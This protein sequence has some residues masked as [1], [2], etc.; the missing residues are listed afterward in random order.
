MR[1]C[2]QGRFRQQIKFLR[3][4][5]LQDGG[6][7]FSDVL[8]EESVAQ[9]LTAIG[10]SSDLSTPD[11]AKKSGPAPLITSIRQSSAV[12]TSGVSGG[13]S[14]GSTMRIYS[15]PMPCKSDGSVRLRMTTLKNSRSSLGTSSEAKSLGFLQM[16]RLVA[17][18][19]GS[20][21]RNA[22]C[23][24]PIN[25]FTANSFNEVKHRL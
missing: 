1:D 16:S 5:F 15:V 13:S 19:R 18:F 24:L 2:N 17:T 11:S 22:I 21:S 12:S 8:T 10:V 23:Y 6:L 25:L 9:A 3:Q 20:C 7:P 14:T 4:Q